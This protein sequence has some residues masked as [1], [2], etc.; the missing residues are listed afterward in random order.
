MAISEGD[1]GWERA[2]SRLLDKVE[3]AVREANRAVLREKISELSDT[4]FMRLAV[5]VARLRGDYLA[6]AM[7]FGQ[8]GRG[9]VSPAE[10]ERLAHA[11]RAYDEA[12]HAF[13]ALERA[14]SR[15]YID[16]SEAALQRVAG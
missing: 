13:E 7:R 8:D 14:I 3:I 10:V 6:E 9:Q 15:G 11:R 12:V 4:A 1:P 16:I 5:T 2:R